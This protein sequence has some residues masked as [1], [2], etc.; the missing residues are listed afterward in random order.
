LDIYVN[1]EGLQHAVE[2]EWDKL[3]LEEINKAIEQNLLVMKEVMM[4][5]R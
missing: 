1:L 4:K 2:E 3:T 5:W